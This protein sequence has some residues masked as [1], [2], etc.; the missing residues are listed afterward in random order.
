MEEEED[1]DE[2]MV[3]GIRREEEDVRSK[4]LWC[5]IILGMKLQEK[6]AQLHHAEGKVVLVLVEVHTAV[7]GYAARKRICVSLIH[8]YLKKWDLCN[9]LES[10]PC[11]QILKSKEITSGRR[12]A[13]VRQQPNEVV[14]DTTPGQT[15]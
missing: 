7:D 6:I 4:K 1:E 2:I 14:L 13:Q 5:Q 3:A 10:T 9:E 11:S 8:F 15:A 12:I